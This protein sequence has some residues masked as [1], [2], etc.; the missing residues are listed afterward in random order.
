M[1]PRTGTMVPPVTRVGT[2][3]LS[4]IRGT[5]DGMEEVE[6]RLEAGDGGPHSLGLPTDDHE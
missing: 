6:K 4:M 2:M 1:S 3:V 5:T